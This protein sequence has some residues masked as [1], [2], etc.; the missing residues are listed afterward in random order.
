MIMRLITALLITLSL[1]FISNLTNAEDR[2]E[3][4][5]VAAL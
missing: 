3:I 2:A 5:V 1:S 4:G